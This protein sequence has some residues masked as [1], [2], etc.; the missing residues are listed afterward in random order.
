MYENV[1]MPSGFKCAGVSAGIKTG[2]VRDMA[3]ILSDTPATS[4]AVFT[5]NQV[6]AAPVKICR[7]HLRHGLS[8]AIVM[9]SGIANACTG[10]EGMVAARDMAA[11]AARMIGCAPQEIFVCSTGKIGPQL[12]LE[13][14][15]AGISILFDEAVR[16]DVKETAEAMMTTDTRAEGVGGGIRCGRQGG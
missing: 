5:T 11:E 4:A 3:L 13:K 14:I 16:A 2:G 15:K 1:T 8:R 12:P 9:N 7:E 10:A 6:C